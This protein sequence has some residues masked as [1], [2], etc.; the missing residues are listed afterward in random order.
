MPCFYPATAYR[1]ENNE[2][3]FDQR[4]G[5]VVSELRVP[6]GQCLGCKLER[7]RQW[8]V[9]CSHEASLYEEN[10]FI[11]L[12]YNDEHLPDGGELDYTDFQKFM[13]RLRKYANRNNRTPK[14]R[15]GP[16]LPYRKIRFFMCGEYG[17]EK[18]RPHFHACIFNFDFDDRIYYKTSAAGS[19]IYLSAQLQNLWSDKG[20]D[21]IGYVTVGDVNSDSAGYVARYSMKKTL[22]RGSALDYEYIDIETGELLY[23]EKEF[24][25]MSLKPGIG[26]GFYKKW[27]RDIFPADMCVIEGVP[28]KPPTF[29]IKK[30]AIDKPDMYTLVSERRAEL[31]V[32]KKDDNTDDRLAQKEQVLKA[33]IRSLK[34]DLI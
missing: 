24:T 12:T 1:C 31:G 20:G 26:T 29:Y 4:K 13:K 9:R 16:Q 22:G 11:T 17:P 8:A 18:S 2:V 21:P 7:A 10:C 14:R 15:H 30:L 33:A 23:K 28:C 34:R 3:V 19:K 5:R 27:F 6:C 25:R 32:A